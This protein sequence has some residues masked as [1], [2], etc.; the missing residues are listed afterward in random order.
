MGGIVVEID[1]IKRGNLYN[2]QNDFTTQ[3]FGSAYL[4][5]P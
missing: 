2:H 3:R 1:I 5:A 4:V